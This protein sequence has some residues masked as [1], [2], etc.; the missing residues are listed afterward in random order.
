MISEDIIKELSQITEEENNIL[1][2]KGDI[3]KSIYSTG[4]SSVIN[5]KKLLEKGR[6]ITIRPHTRFVRFPA[7]YHDYIEAIY[8]CKGST[9]HI[10]NGQQ[11]KLQQGELLF[12]GMNARHE[13]LKADKDDIAVNF[14]ILPQFFDEP[15]KMIEQYDTP[16]KNFLTECLAGKSSG[17]T[18]YIHFKCAD[19]KPVQNLIENLLFT[20]KSDLNNKQSINKSTMGLLFMHLMNNTEHL[21]FGSIAS[22]AVM[23]VISYIEE[24]YKSGSLTEIADKLN[25]DMARLSKDIKAITGLTY[26]QLVQQKRLTQAAYLLQHTRLSIY[27]IAQAVGYNNT[28]YFHKLFLS[29]FEASPHQYRKCK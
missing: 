10:I 12:L 6:I 16:L 1:K 18:Y 20:I 26:T 2:S 24:N 14:I 29:A 28:T 5:A 21:Q 15:I 7:H 13:I 3:D 22:H 23:Q 8:M 4:N 19:I 27:D 11:I 9:V 17:E 25:L